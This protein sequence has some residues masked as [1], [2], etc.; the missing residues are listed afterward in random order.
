MVQWNHSIPVTLGTNNSPDY[1]GVLI[2]GVNLYY[3]A[4]FGTFVSVLNTGVSSFQGVLD[5]GVSLYMWF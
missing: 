1:R 2:S 4:Q 5:G 3:K